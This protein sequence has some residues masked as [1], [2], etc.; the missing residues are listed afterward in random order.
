LRPGDDPVMPLG[1]T[2]LYFFDLRAGSSTYGM[3]LLVIATDSMGQE[4]EYYF[5]EKVKLPANLTDAHFD[6]ARLKNNP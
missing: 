2:R 1:G 4:V 3:P 6:P 5:F